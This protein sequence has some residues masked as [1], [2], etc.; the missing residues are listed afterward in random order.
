MYLAVK[1]QLNNLSKEDYLIL[2]ELSHISKNLYNQAL[3]EY[4]QAFFEKRS[5]D[6]S[7]YTNDKLLRG[8][9]NYSQLQ[10]QISQQT[11][12]S[13]DEAM[14]SFWELKK[15]EPKTRLPKY[16]DKDGF[17]DICIPTIPR[18]LKKKGILTI[19]YSRE[20]KKMHKNVNIKVPSNIISKDLCQILISPKHNAR[21]FEISYIYKVE[22][23]K[24]EINNQALAI[25][26]GINNLCTCVDTLGNSFIMDGKRLKSFN[27]WYNK[28]LSRLSSIKD[29]QKIKGYTDKM[30]RITKKRN[31]R[32][33]DFIHK[34]CKYI[35]NYLQ[36]NNIG[37]LVL[38]MNVDFQCNSNMGRKNN[39]EFTQIPF[40]K[41]R[42]NLEY[43]CKLYGI[44]FVVQEESYTSKAS[45]WDKDVIPVYGDKEIPKFSGKRAYRGQYRTKEGKLLNADINGALNIL[46]KSNVV[47]LETLY[48]RGE[49]V[50][51]MR[52]R[53]V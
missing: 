19:P 41:I 52:I 47:S 7:Y 51:P 15:Q 13:V 8:T 26:L 36:E 22:S 10:A 30:Y 9:E 4:R 23:Q 18:N 44:N 42:D 2:K 50:T 24:Q 28:E 35:I 14:K 40:G 49:L 25:D 31:N 12:M 37:N 29:K 16:L 1:Q 48:S 27:Q 20:F 39:Q 21:F 38:G 32:V 3:Y 6:V 45:F 46:R 33:R 34:T 5:Q 17:Y 53:V 11:L 43:L